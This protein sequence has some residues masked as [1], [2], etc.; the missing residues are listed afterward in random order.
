MY[1]RMYAFTQYYVDMCVYEVIRRSHAQHKIMHM[2]ACLCVH[3]YMHTCISNTCQYIIYITILL[4]VDL[5]SSLTY[6]MMTQPLPIAGKIPIKTLVAK[7][8]PTMYSTSQKKFTVV[9]NNYT[10]YI[11]PNT[12][13]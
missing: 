9:C 13:Q 10:G 1:V 8:L 7:Q 4:V 5:C 6:F 3:N 12:T 11:G 2:H